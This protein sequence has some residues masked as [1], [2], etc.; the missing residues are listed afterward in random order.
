MNNIQYT[1]VEVTLSAGS[2]TAQAEIDVPEGA[3]THI[4]LVKEGN[5][6]EIV[7]LEIL[8]NNSRVLSP[9]DIRFSERTTTGSFLDGLRP[10]SNINGGRKL[11]VRLS[12]VKPT[13]AADLNVQV[14]FVTQQETY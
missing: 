2:S 11:Q 7:N 9:I 10:V 8:Q 12:A 4:G 5:A 6:T 14:V 1:T 3:V 13:R